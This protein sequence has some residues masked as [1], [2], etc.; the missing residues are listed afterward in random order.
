MKNWFLLAMVFVIGLFGSPVFAFAPSGDGV[1]IGASADA[2]MVGATIPDGVEQL[3]TNMG[4]LLVAT[5]MTLLFAP[6]RLSATGP[7]TNAPERYDKGARRLLLKIRKTFDKMTVSP[8]LK[9]Q[10]S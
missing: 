9:R 8:V 7:A 4:T 10:A 2:A 5:L 1:Y 6:I 3:G